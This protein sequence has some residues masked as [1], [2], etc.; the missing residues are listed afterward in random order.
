MTDGGIDPVVVGA[1]AVTA[2]AKLIFSFKNGDIKP[3]TMRPEWSGIPYLSDRFGYHPMPDGK[4]H[5][6]LL[7]KG[8]IREIREA[9]RHF[10][11]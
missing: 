9:W 7:R 3:C 6:R 8:I 11:Q 1:G 2:A 10:R 4:F 5:H